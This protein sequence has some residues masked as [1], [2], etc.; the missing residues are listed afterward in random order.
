MNLENG[1]ARFGL[2]SPKEL[3]T[4][5]NLHL[6]LV[7]KSVPEVL[8]YQGTCE[9]SLQSWTHW[10]VNHKPWDCKTVLWNSFDG[11]QILLSPG[12]TGLGVGISFFFFKCFWHLNRSH[13]ANTR[14]ASKHLWLLFC[15]WTHTPSQV[16]VR[17]CVNTATVL[18]PGVDVCWSCT[19]QLGYVC[20]LDQQNPAT[21][22]W[23]FILDL[24]SGWCGLRVLNN[25]MH[26]SEKEVNRNKSET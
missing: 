3:F 22:P 1:I 6:S 15:I 7:P 14:H 11:K 24:W 25:E 13:V 21:V 18:L 4:C 26:S 2:F 19:K 10:L 5:R 8:S 23:L 12:S 16:D 17:C 9:R 20:L